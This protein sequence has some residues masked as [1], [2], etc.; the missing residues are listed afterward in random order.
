MA[1]EVQGRDLTRDVTVTLSG[2]K[3]I[4]LGA[5]QSA[6][7]F[8]GKWK[9][10]GQQ[11][12]VAIKHYRLALNDPPEIVEAVNRRLI[13][14]SQTWFDLDHPH[15]LP[16]Y[17]LC[18]GLGL[19]VAL[20]CPLHLNGNILQYMSKVECSSAVRLKFI[21]EIAA[22]L[23]YLH[24]R[25]PG[26]VHADL[27]CGNILIND[28]EQA[29][30]ADFGRSKKI[31]IAGYTTAL[32]CGSTRHMAPELFPEETP[33]GDEVDPDMIFCMAT[34]MYAFAMVCFEIL[35]GNV[36]F[37]ALRYDYQVISAIRRSKRPEPTLEV[38]QS[39]PLDVWEIM[40]RCWNQDPGQRPSAGE[41][42]EF[43]AK[44]PVS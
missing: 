19:T 25:V 42:V 2:E 10:Q 24:S 35:T 21:N 22:G 38:Q 12:L 13:R 28:Q 26:V 3:R 37:K 34:D 7:I 16:C 5:G 27:H 36:P 39:I 14:E 41:V 23:L 6:D 33:E 31:G 4:P 44:V 8:R 30:L 20:V 9:D 18:D 43:L 17:G 15:V 40:Y 11:K 29:L 1:L 32:F